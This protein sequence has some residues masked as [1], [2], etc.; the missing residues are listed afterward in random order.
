MLAFPS[1][2]RV[3]SRHAGREPSLRVGDAER[4]RVVDE[5]TGHCG[6]G[7]LTLEEL[8]D[9]VERALGARTEIEF[10]EVTRDLPASRAGA[11]LPAPAGSPRPSGRWV[12]ALMSESVR[13][14]RW[15][16]APRTRAVAV[17]GS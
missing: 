10:A 16:P 8:S 3:T 7:R 6:A 2:P 5:L 13:R 12:V 11:P 4:E 14:G 17:M 15:R 1:N 9:R